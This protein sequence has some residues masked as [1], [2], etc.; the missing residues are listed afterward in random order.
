MNT[1]SDCRI[2]PRRFFRL[3]PT[4]RLLRPGL[5]LTAVAVAAAAILVACIQG[6]WDYYPKDP[7]YFQGVSVTGYALADRPIENVCFERLLS[8]GEEN[9]QAFAFYDSAD[10][11]IKGRF[12]GVER[13]LSLTA[14][15]DT[16][17]CFKGNPADTVERGRNYDL[18]A[19]LTWDSSGTRVTSLI[20]GT[21]RVPVSFS[22]HK[23]A[24]APKIAFSPGIPDNIFDLDFIRLL[25]RSVQGV[26][27]IEFPEL[28]QFVDTSITQKDIDTSKA[29]QAFILKD[30]KRAKTRL[31]ELMGEDLVPYNEN[32]TLYYMNGDFNT[33]SHYFSSDRSSDVQSVLITQQFDS[34]S[35]RPS[36][37]FDSPTGKKP[38]SFQYYFPGNHRRLLIY[39]DAK[40]AKGWN[41]LDSL[42]VVNVW[43]HT[44]RN[45]LFFYGME[46]PYY[47]WLSTV[48]QVQGG[49][50]GDAD[51][52][53]KGKYN[54][55]GGHGV[56]VG[57][58][59]DTFDLFIKV[60][61]LSK[62]KSYP[63]PLVHGAKCNEDGWFYG[64]D[65]R[66]YLRPWCSGKNWTGQECGLDVIRASLEA[67]FSQ[68]SVDTALKARVSGLYDSVSRDTATLRRGTEEFC[69]D[70]N[71]PA[72]GGACEKSRN[73]CLDS[74]GKN[75]CKEALWKFC[76]DN[77]WSPPQCNPGLASYC[78]DKPR[79]SEV[80]CRHADI[81]CA[82]PANA[83]S[84]LCK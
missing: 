27:L 24:K 5:G 7:P 32:A 37:S 31:V 10:V 73:E 22:I 55:T 64:K 25:P 71:F 34:N 28:A 2:A 35:S 72:A 62:F 20:R 84:P 69:V 38:D 76:L 1:N 54:V 67:D 56:F 14:I 15:I 36:T 61:S 11:R 77:A 53:V 26:M 68:D 9:T 49:G 75:S 18:T 57:G 30:G 46:Q 50:G 58:I 19:S 78:H 70:R 82:D 74:K 59:P 79:L 41:L 40:S 16:P 63:L 21:A 13:D 23:T 42:G 12:S 80:L 44:G 6:P 17:N 83:G 43:F 33:L 51:P 8:L 60:D 66:D 52:R 3:S 47:A 48:T 4:L 45:R 65:C 39:P 29:I 81:W